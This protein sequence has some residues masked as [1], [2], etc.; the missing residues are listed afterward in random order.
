APS[1]ATGSR[2]AS[3]SART[4]SSSARLSATARSHWHQ[5]PRGVILWPLHTGKEESMGEPKLHGLMMDR[6]PLTLTTIVERAELLTPGR[7]VVSRRPDGSI[8]RTTVGD[9]VRRA[10]RLATALAAL[11]VRDGD[12]VATL[13]WN[14]PEHLELYYALP[15]MGAVIHTINPRLHPDELSFIAGDA[16]DKVLVI[17]ETLLEKLEAFRDGWDFEHVVVVSH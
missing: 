10:R 1:S 8:H 4:S 6:F 9:C 2:S 13:L 3:S 11:G 12:R 15:L 14:Q 7:K 5:R 17:D 16:E